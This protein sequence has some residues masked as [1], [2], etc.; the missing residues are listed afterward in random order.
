VE[1]PSTVIHVAGQFGYEAAMKTRQV[2]APVLIP[3]AMVSAMPS[4][5]SAA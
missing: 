3:M 1:L 4:F 2:P 5:G